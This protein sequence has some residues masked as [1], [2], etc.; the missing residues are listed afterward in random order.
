MHPAGRLDDAA[1]RPQL[2]LDA[3]RAARRREARLRDTAKALVLGHHVE[4]PL[5]DIA[6]VHRRKVDVTAIGEGPV[7]LQRVAADDGD[8]AQGGLDA[9]AGREAVEAAG[10]EVAGCVRHLG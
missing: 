4:D 6:R 10:R 9:G 5:A 3:E 8:A 1:P 2:R 7:Q